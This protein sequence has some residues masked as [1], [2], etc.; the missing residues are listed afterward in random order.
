MKCNGKI[1]RLPAHILEELYSRLRNGEPQVRL[2]VW[3]NGLPEVQA[4]L[5]EHFAGRPIRQQNLTE[6]RDRNHSAWLHKKFPSESQPAPK[7]ASDP[8]LDDICQIC[9]SLILEVLSLCLSWY[10]RGLGDALTGVPPNN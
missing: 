4:V 3:L 6:W 1:G 2:V 7:K 9:P 10:R 8:T 5:A